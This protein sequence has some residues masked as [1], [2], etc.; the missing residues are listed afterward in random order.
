MKKGLS[1]QTNKPNPCVKT[2]LPYSFRDLSVFE[3]SRRQR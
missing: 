3:C 1:P 2:S